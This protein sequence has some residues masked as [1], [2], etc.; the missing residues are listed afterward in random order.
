MKDEKLI[1]TFDKQANVYE[2]RRKK[3]TEKKWREQL[4]RCAKGRVLEVGV[5]AGG[6]F[7]F[8]PKNVVVTAVDFSNEMLCRAKAAAA[9]YGIQAEF[10]HSDIESLSFPDDSFDTIISTLTCC[11][12][13]DPLA[14][15]IAFNQ[16]C[17]KD[18]QIL[19]ME[20]G[21][22]S[23][24]FVGSIQTAIDPFFSKIVGCHLTR[25]MNRL[26]QQ[27]NLQISKTERHFFDAVHLI[28]AK[29]NKYV[30]IAS[31]P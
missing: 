10:V 25:D 19:L 26:F 29:P 17:K 20:H 5:G 16:W 11:G 15:L 23:N 4:I 30:D 3:Q 1:R 14:V 21:I 18:G 12:Y 31:H 24:R 13:K 8:Y 6:N 9:E 22:S 27:S 2:K 28:W 7:P